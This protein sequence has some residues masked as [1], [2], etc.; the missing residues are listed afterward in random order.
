MRYLIT[1]TA[2]CL[3]ILLFLFHSNTYC[4]N[5][6]SNL[7]CMYTFDGNTDDQGIN[8]Y[9]G[10]AHGPILSADRFNY[11]NKAFLFNGTSDYISIPSD[12]LN[13]MQQGTILTWIKLDEINRQHA[14]LVKSKT[15]VADYFQLIVDED[16]TVRVAININYNSGDHSFKS[17]STLEMNKW[18]SVAVTWDGN[19]SKIFINGLLDSTVTNKNTIPDIDYNTYIG[20]NDVNNSTSTNAFFKGIIDDLRIYN[21]T[22]SESEIEQMYQQNSAYNKIIG[23]I[24]TSS[25][26]LGYTA[27]VGGATVN[28]IPY[29][30]STVTDIYGDF[31]LSNIPVGECILQIESSYFQTLTKSI[32]INIGDNII[33]SIEIFKPKCQNMYTQQDVDQLLDKIKSEKDAI[34][35]QKNAT[36]T[37]LNTSI[38]SM[39]TQGYLDKAIEEAEKRGELK[40][41]INGDGK[42]GLEEVIKYLETISG[43]RVESL[44]IFP[45]ERKYYLAE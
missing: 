22:V 42:V 36:I 30:L 9:N 39:Y 18:Y 16:N 31:K 40:Y 45:E 33:N 43:V 25:E 34:I 32:Q 44:I 15:Y 29:N 1:I 14:I 2:S 10:T 6:D 26:I 19:E 38:A 27:S 35:A 13:N 37:Q 24:I 3:G 23:K 11:D 7:V 8:A 20:G 21:R 4:E 41:D 12:A 17:N 28:A 5:I